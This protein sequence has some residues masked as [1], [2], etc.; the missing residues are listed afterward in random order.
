MGLCFENLSCDCFLYLAVI[1]L[2]LSFTSLTYPWHFRFVAQNPQHKVL[3]GTEHWEFVVAATGTPDGVSCEETVLRYFMK[4]DD[5]PPQVSCDGSGLCSSV[6]TCVITCENAKA[7]GANIVPVPYSA[8]VSERVC[9]DNL[10]GACEYS[11]E[12]TR[13]ESELM[14]DDI[15]HFVEDSVESRSC[16]IEACGRSDPCRVPF[17][18]HAILAFKGGN[19]PLWN[20]HYED[21]FVDAFATTVNAGRHNDGELF[22]PGDIKVLMVTEWYRSDEDEDNENVKALGT[23]LVAEISIFN[24]NATVPEYEVAVEGEGPTDPLPSNVTKKEKAKQAWDNV[25]HSIED[26]WDDLG[27]PPKM[28]CEESDTYPLAKSALHVHMELE[29]PSFMKELL[30]QMEENERKVGGGN[31]SYSSPFLPLYR[32]QS[33]KDSSKFLSSWTIKTEIGG[34]IIH[35]HAVANV[36]DIDKDTILYYTSNAPLMAIILSIVLCLCSFGCCWGRS[37]ARRRYEMHATSLMEKLAAR[38]E[39]K[40][41]GRY[42]QVGVLGNDEENGDEEVPVVSGVEYRDNPVGNVILEMTERSG[43]KENETN[44]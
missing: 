5:N 38:S 27:G 12:Q 32:T 15:C 35:N 25:L 30:L 14:S 31:F 22:G 18:V 21:M 33:Y 41:R 28:V 1:C 7:A 11:C 42:S 16:H 13:I 34:G 10:W 17:V 44:E 26:A 40:Q 20:R 2:S 6:E 4:E 24:P 37:C 19:T 39:R 3:Q 9:G 43:E 23:K 29:R 36:R 8:G